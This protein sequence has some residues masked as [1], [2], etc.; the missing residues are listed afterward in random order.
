M[1]KVLNRIGFCQTF[2]NKSNTF[3]RMELC[4]DK[5]AEEMKKKKKMFFTENKI[6]N[7]PILDSKFA[8]LF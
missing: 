4:A 6:R 2:A 3:D 1:D 5:D 7:R 8:E